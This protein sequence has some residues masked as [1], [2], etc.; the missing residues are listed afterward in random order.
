[1]TIPAND[2]LVFDESQFNTASP[3]AFTFSEFG[4]DVI[5]LRRRRPA[6]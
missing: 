6:F 5:C 3:V 4:E 1:M 2:Y